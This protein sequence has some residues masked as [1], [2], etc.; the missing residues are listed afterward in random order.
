M[1]LDA[2]ERV[3]VPPAPRRSFQFELPHGLPRNEEFAQNF[4]A[5]QGD[6]AGC[7]VCGIA[8]DDPESGIA[9]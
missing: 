9:R 5:P 6:L 1:L 2:Q 4:P 7:A 3:A 8:G